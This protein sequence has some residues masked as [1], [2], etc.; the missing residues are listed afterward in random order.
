[1]SITSFLNIAQNRYNTG[2]MGTRT[3]L[4]TRALGDLVG[5]VTLFALLFVLVSIFPGLDAVIKNWPTTAT[6]GAA[7]TL[8]SYFFW[9]KVEKLNGNW[10]LGVLATIGLA[11]AFLPVDVIFGEI[12]HPS[13]D[14]VKS[15]TS[16]ISFWLTLF[17]CPLTT[18]AA[19]A[20]WARSVT[21]RVCTGPL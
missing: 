14:I 21:L 10:P 19:L 4:Q 20:G 5:C 16:T 8:I 9:V 1:M 7:F 6:L 17:I 18:M 13:G 15:A 2:A 3:A 12:V 11:L